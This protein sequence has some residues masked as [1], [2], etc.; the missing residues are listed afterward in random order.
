MPVRN[1]AP[2][3]SKRCQNRKLASCHSDFHE[4]NTMPDTT[5]TVPRT[6]SNVVGSP[7]IVTAMAALT[8]GLTD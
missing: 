6:I 3:G 4:I 8:S 7:S 5:K 1:A 2:I